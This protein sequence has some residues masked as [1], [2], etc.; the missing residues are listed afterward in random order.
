[1]FFETRG[2]CSA[3]YIRRA[4]HWW[5]LG[6]SPKAS[7]FIPAKE[8]VFAIWKVNKM[9]S[10]QEVHHEPDTL[11]ELIG[12][13]EQHGDTFRR[14]STPNESG[15]GREIWSDISQTLRRMEFGLESI[16]ERLQKQ[17]S[18]LFEA[19]DEIGAKV[20]KV[21]LAQS[22]NGQEIS[23]VWQKLRGSPSPQGRQGA[24][25]ATGLRESGHE[26]RKLGPRSPEVSPRRRTLPSLPE[27]RPG[28]IPLLEPEGKDELME[29]LTR[30]QEIAERKHDTG[31]E[32]TR[33]SGKPIVKPT[34]Y[35]GTTT[36]E[37]YKAQFELVSN[38]NA[39]DDRT[40]AAYLATSLKGP[41]QA[42]LGD[43]EPA[44]R[45]EL[46]ALMAALD[47][48]FGAENQTE[49]HRAQLKSR[50][51]KREESLPELAQAIRRL[52][53]LAYPDATATLREALGRD[54]F[55]DAL[56]DSAMRWRIHQTR[57]K[58]MKEALTVAVELEAF[59][60]A[61]RQR[62]GARAV[63]PPRQEGRSTG[64]SPAPTEARTLR[65][66]VQ[67]MRSLLQKLLDG[68]SRPSGQRQQGGARSRGPPAGYPGCHSCGALDHYRRD[69]PVGGQQQQGNEGQPDL[70]AEARL[71]PQGNG[72]FNR[73]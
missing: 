2:F 6:G 27:D 69:C 73:Q 24:D 13:E 55:L 61:D 10:R 72:S 19:V 4:L 29:S 51:R 49:L 9:A 71:T 26:S 42:I 17:S 48:R 21:E 37:D 23:R 60:A 44:Q 12:K 31:R 7:K 5:Q 28:P 36:W 33:R 39:W 53:R 18:E 1:M 8:E 35:D 3:L 11:G 70:R 41:A 46:G 58:S 32:N 25:M 30:L 52:T 16:E 15:L 66:E 56:P 43:L 67:E 14:L 63:Y 40:K 50:V 20:E 47:S 57:P 38:L 59:Q 64:E 45:T 65:D 62:P 54:H 22:S 68:Q 34:T